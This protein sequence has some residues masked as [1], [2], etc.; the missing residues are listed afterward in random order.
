MSK[1]KGVREVAWY[2]CPG[3][4]Q[5]VVAN[6]FAYIGHLESPHGTTILD[7]HDPKHPRE[8]A[9]LAMPPGTHSHKV[10]V[11]NDVMVVNH[12]ILDEREAGDAKGGLGIYDVHDPKHPREVARWVTP[13]KGVHRFT[14]TASTGTARRPSTATSATS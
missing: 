3:G 6:G 11:G 10:R 13:G 14:S 4:G 2:D 8:V 12:E 9:R 1:A 7:V 5:V